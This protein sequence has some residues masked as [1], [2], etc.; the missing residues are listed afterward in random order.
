MSKP[1]REELTELGKQ[2][3]QLQFQLS[4]ALLKL[5][6]RPLGPPRPTND[7]QGA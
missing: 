4:L 1:I 5:K 7:N 2:V 3:V 6:Q